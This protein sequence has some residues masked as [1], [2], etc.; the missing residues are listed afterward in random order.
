MHHLAK[1]FGDQSG[2]G[3]DTAISCFWKW[4]PS[5]ILDLL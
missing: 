1:F 5:T 3:R 2:C 4:W